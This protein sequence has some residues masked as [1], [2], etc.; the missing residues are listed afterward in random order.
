MTRNIKRKHED[1][2]IESHDEKHKG[3][4]EDRLIKNHDEKTWRL[5]D[6]DRESWR[7]NM[8]E[9]H[10][11]KS[12]R[13][14][15]QAIY[16]YLISC[17]IES[18]FRVELSSQASQL[19]LSSQI[20]LLNS[21]WV[22]RFNFSTRSDTFSKKIQLNLN[23]ST[24]LDAISLNILHDSLLN[25]L[26]DFLSNILHDS[27]LNILHDSLSNSLHDFFHDFLHDSLPH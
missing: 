24:Q 23:L 13:L 8:V 9:S 1:C 27:L 3:K 4:H 12:C 10:E 15:D 22:L 20:Q 17:W 14:F 19:D 25:I 21:I 7:E 2:L 26:H 18:S 5:F 11:G 16:I 6:F